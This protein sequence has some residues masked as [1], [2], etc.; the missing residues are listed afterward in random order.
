MGDPLLVLPRYWDTD[1]AAHLQDV[2]Q[3]NLEAAAYAE[4]NRQLELDYYDI[5]CSP[6]YGPLP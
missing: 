6:T 1:A 5:V 4:S 3:L 2:I